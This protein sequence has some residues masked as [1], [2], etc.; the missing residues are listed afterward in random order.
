[1]QASWLDGLVLAHG[2]VELGLDPPGGQ[3][4]VKGYVE[5]AAMCSGDFKQP[6]SY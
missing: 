3:G 5:Q 1:M 2:W 4:H 6:V